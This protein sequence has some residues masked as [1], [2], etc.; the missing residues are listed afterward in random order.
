MVETAQGS[1]RGVGSLTS[2]AKSS[3]GSSSEIAASAAA[4]QQRALVESA[5]AIAQYR[6]RSTERVRQALL[7]ICSRYE[8]AE[9]AIYK[10][11]VGGGKMAEGPSIRFAEAALQAWGNVRISSTITFENDEI[12]NMNVCVLDLETNSSYAEDVTLTKTVERKF[13][14]DGQLII[15]TRMNSSNE[16]IY[17]VEASESDMVTKTNAMK[18]K[19]IR[20]NGLRLIPQD[21]I[22]EAV[23]KIR[24]VL[25]RGDQEISAEDLKRKIIDAFKEQGV[26]VEDLEKMLGHSM[27]GVSKLELEYLRQ[28]Y[29]TI[30]DGEAVW[31]DY[32]GVKIDPKPKAPPSQTAPT[33][34]DKEALA[35]KPAASTPAASP[36]QGAETKRR[37]RPR[38][39]QPAA[40]A[41][42][43]GV[44]KA[45][46]P[47][48]TTQQPA[49]APASSAEIDKPPIAPESAAVQADPNE[50]DDSGA[51]WV[52]PPAAEEQAAAEPEPTSEEGP[53]QEE[54][55]AEPQDGSE[56]VG[57]GAPKSAR[58]AVDPLYEIRAHAKDAETQHSVEVL[59]AKAKAAIERL[60][61]EEAKDVLKNVNFESMADFNR[62]GKV[63]LR[64]LLKN[65]LEIAER[66]WGKKAS[67]S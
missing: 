57:A 32:I 47:P 36:A 17:I 41:S 42:T 49:P 67:A 30:R 51:P 29:A 12:R 66:L 63:P 53:S 3:N 23:D 9:G 8:F 38:K 10:R 6:P 1:T 15:A 54:P 13:V 40:P 55:D 65:C 11:A 34:G 56:T 16:K 59:R 46:A 61:D 39:E 22:A 27:K 44:D 45:A 19:A 14:K 52:D 58:Q 26:M 48:T 50:L 64:A 24:E 33:T 31:S 2:L 43:A 7:D 35:D 28:I 5:Y 20:N 18:S 21:I 25:H 37:G 4:A 62:A 60:P